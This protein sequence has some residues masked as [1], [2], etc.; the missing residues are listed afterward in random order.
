MTL[1]TTLVFIGQIVPSN[2]R[3]TEID[4]IE[5]NMRNESQFLIYQKLIVNVIN[6]NN[7]FTK[8]W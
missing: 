1:E 8:K 4:A 2:R 7:P 6:I 5:K 3:K